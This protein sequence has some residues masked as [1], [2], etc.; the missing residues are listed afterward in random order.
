MTTGDVLTPDED[1]TGGRFSI[2]DRRH[3]NWLAWFRTVEQAREWVERCFPDPV[4]LIVWD[5]TEGREVY[6][7]HGPLVT[8]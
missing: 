7:W 6:R 3:G 2:I 1:E 4:G 5:E 8:P